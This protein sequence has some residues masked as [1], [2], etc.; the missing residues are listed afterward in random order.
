[1]RIVFVKIGRANIIHYSKEKTQAVQDKKCNLQQEGVSGPRYAEHDNWNGSGL[2]LA[3]IRAALTN[4]KGD[5]PR[6]HHGYN[7]SINPEH[8]V[9]MAEITWFTEGFGKLDRRRRIHVHR[10]VRHAAGALRLS[11]MWH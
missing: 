11:A 4:R 3:A 9:W 10:A 6:Q 1:M 5:D 2:S 8:I 7:M